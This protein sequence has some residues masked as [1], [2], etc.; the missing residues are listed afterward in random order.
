[1]WSMFCSLVGTLL[2]VQD[3]GHRKVTGNSKLC[4]YEHVGGVTDWPDVKKMFVMY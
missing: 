4:K 2:S 1:M 3:C